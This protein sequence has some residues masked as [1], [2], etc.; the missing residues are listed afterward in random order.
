MVA[1]AAV[2]VPAARPLLAA[3][4]ETVCAAVAAEGAGPRTM[5]TILAQEATAATDLYGLLF[6]IEGV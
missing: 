5:V 3:E 2:A 1:A 4:E 6:G